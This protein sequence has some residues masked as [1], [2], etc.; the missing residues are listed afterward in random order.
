[1][2]DL[3]AAIA[4]A[5]IPPLHQPLNGMSTT[6]PLPLQNGQKHANTTSFLT[7][8]S[9]MPAAMPSANFNG[10]LE[11]EATT[12]DPAA[13]PE[14]A[15]F[16]DSVVWPSDAYFDWNRLGPLDG[17][18]D[19]D[20]VP[21]SSPPTGATITPRF[22]SKTKGTPSMRSDVSHLRATPRGERESDGEEFSDDDM[23]DEDLFLPI[24]DVPVPPEALHE[25]D[26]GVTRDAMRLLGVETQDQMAT[27]VQK[28]L[29]GVRGA[30][31]VTPDSLEKLKG[32]LS[33]TRAPGP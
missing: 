15:Q 30:D 10:Y 5:P 11:E 31:E 22:K 4:R 17:E 19:A 2:S 7:P 29:D 21:D 18:N 20:F 6:F 1:M 3:Q 13:I 14:L 16:F 9:S 32:L 26:S 27:A 23:V 28:I 12:I 33:L 8:F 24:E 25:P